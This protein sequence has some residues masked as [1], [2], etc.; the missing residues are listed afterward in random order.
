MTC[1]K[2][3]HVPFHLVNI[4]KPL[5]TESLVMIFITCHF[6]NLGNMSKVTSN[7]KLCLISLPS[8]ESMKFSTFFISPGNSRFSLKFR[9]TH[10]E[11]QLILPNTHGLFHWYPR[12]GVRGFFLGKP[13]NNKRISKMKI[14]CG[15]LQHFFGGG[16]VVSLVYVHDV[17]FVDIPYSLHAQ[18]RQFQAR[19]KD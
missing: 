17:S 6:K 13:N 19:K 9:Y 2:L 16:G 5:Q 3:P 8:N 1:I 4:I 15:A 18:P 11:F 7:R 14:Y 12:Q 10:L